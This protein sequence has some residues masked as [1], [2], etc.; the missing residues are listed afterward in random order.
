VNVYIFSYHLDIV[1]KYRDNTICTVRYF[2][3]SEGHEFLSSG[4]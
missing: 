2:Q 1:L 3:A 4:V